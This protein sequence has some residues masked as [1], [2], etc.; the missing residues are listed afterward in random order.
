MGLLCR[1][2]LAARC[3]GAPVVLHRMGIMVPLCL[4]LRSL[5]CGNEARQFLRL[6]SEAEGADSGR[7]HTA[8]QG[9]KAQASIRKK[10]TLYRS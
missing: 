4:R 2:Y 8:G 10:Q 9:S 6:S 3:M 1:L 7:M 5:C